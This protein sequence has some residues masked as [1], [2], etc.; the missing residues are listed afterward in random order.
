MARG[1]KGE[2]RPADPLK[3]GILVMRIAVGDLSEDEARKL[4]KKPKRRSKR[5]KAAA[6]RAK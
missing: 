5:P 2:Y 3:G 6:K 4:A 1:P